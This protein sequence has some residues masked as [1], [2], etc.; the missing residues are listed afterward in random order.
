MIE[1]AISNKESCN[2]YVN[3]LRA[4]EERS[5]LEMQLRL[6]GVPNGNLVA[7]EAHYHRTKNCYTHNINN[8]FS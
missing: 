3:M 4:D 5:D 1:S 7:V 8:I 6:H 2:I